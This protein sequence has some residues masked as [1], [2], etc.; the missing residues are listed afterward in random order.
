VG[1]GPV[2][3][4]KNSEGRLAVLSNDD[5]H[6]LYGGPLV[7]L[8]NKFSASASEIVAG[9]L[10]DYGRAVI[11]GSEHTHGK[12]TVQSIID[13]DDSI[14]F[15]NMEQYKTLGALKLTIQKFYRIS[16]ESTQYRGVLPD[17]VLPDRFSYVKSGEKYLDFALPWDTVAPAHYNMWRNKISGLPELRAMSRKRVEA[18]KDFMEIDRESRIMLERQK[19]TLQSLNID[20]VRKEREEALKLRDTKGFHG[21]DE[22]D[23]NHPDKVFTR[24]E[25]R[26][27][28]EKDVN[29]DIYVREA[30]AVLDDM[31][32]LPEGPTSVATSAAASGSAR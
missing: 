32:S 21:I 3:Q 17:I 7:V 16:G 1:K 9:A 24:E 20:V 11:I 18:N 12:G 27:L 14:P 31:I 29:G 22:P 26:A 8:V 15:G 23:K 5:A 19:K 25:R 10:Q 6:V 2:V 13:L 30:A 4:V 28:W